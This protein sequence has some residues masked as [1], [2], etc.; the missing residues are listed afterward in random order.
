MLNRAADFWT[1]AWAYLTLAATA[2]WPLLVLLALLAGFYY[3]ADF[4][5][6][7]IVGSLH[8][9]A[10]IVPVVLVTVALA[11]SSVPW[12][13]SSLGLILCAGIAGGLIG[14]TVIGV[15]FLISLNIFGKHWNEAFS[16]LRSRHYKNYLRL[17]IDQSGAL[18]IYPIGLERVPKDRS[19]ANP[20][21]SPTLI[22]PPILI[23]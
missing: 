10:Q 22:E 21:L 13:H 17:R 8:T 6:R 23:R 9:C 3:L 7:G 15:Y 11:R 20:G 1:G 16:A 14:S 4:K 12:A 18:T 19:A 5:A 2:P